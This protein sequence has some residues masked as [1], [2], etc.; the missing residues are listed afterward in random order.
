MLII[1]LFRLIPHVEQK[2]GVQHSM[3]AVCRDAGM[4]AQAAYDHMGD[5]L[6]ERYRDWYLALATLPSWGQQ[7]DAQVQRYI[8]GV[9]RVVQANLHWRYS[10]ARAKTPS[11]CYLT[12]NT[13]SNQPVTLEASQRKF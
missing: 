3:V 6:K 4:S 11:C 5:L 13:V 7:I 10:G 2:D 9:Q 8:E 12:S 1:Y